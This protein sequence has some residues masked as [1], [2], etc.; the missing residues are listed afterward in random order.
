MVGDDIRRYSLEEP[1]E[2]R[3][4]G[5]TETRADAPEHEL[6]EA[7]WR[8]ARLARPGPGKTSV[9]LRIDNDVLEWFRA[10]G[11]GYPTRINAVLRAYAE[12]KRQ[13]G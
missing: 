1:R 9:H 7:F 11:P 5:E 10:Q 13:G 2:R 8:N 4:K 12:V 3:R 6:D